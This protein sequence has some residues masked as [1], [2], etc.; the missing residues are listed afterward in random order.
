MNAVRQFLR[1]PLLAPIIL[2][3]LM[4]M[5]FSWSAEVGFSWMLWPSDLRWL[6]VICWIGAALCIGI[7]GFRTWDR[8]TYEVHNN[9]QKKA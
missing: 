9:E 2:M 1:D 8:L 7:A 5:S 3:T 6:A 4:P